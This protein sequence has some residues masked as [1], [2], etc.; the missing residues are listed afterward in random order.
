MMNGRRSPSCTPT[1][2]LSADRLEHEEHR[3]H[4]WWLPT[5]SLNH[6]PSVQGLAGASPYAHGRPFEL[7]G[8]VPYVSGEEI[9]KMNFQTS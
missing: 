7:H 2:R 1:T 8:F 9:S 6:R 3:S 5:P 4:D